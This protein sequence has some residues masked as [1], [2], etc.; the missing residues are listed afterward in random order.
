MI[1]VDN[2]RMSGEVTDIETT[3][4]VSVRTLGMLYS[5]QLSGLTNHC[6]QY[7][8]RYVIGQIYFINA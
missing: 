3:L 1:W 8:E 7:A 2:E 4:A 5:V 6:H